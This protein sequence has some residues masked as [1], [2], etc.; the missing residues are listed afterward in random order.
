MINLNSIASID[1]LCKIVR[2]KKF[3]QYLDISWCKLPPKGLLVISDELV[4]NPKCIKSLNLGY[5]SLC[6]NPQS[7]QQM[8]DSEDFLFNINEYLQS[9]KLILNHLDLSGM[10]IIRE[11][12]VEVCKSIANNDVLL[13]VHLNDNGIRSEMDY[14]LEIMDL[15]GLDDKIFKEKPGQINKSVS[16]GESI[17]KIVD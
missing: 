9:D 2:T 4:I 13:S 1:I 10:N 12:M 3:I 14:T 8:F 7:E 16:N 11:Q 5:N 17:R 15:F 6:F